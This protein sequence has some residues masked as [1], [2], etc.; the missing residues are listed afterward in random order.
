MQ[1]RRIDPRTFFTAKA[2]ADGWKL[3]EVRGPGLACTGCDAS[4]GV[5]EI[6]SALA[7]DGRLFCGACSKRAGIEADRP[8]S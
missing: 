6:V 5:G 7:D 8:R 3:M 2:A 4:L 1:P